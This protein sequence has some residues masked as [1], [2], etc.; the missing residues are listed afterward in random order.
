MAARSTFKI[1]DDVRD[2]LSRSTITA[3]TVTLPPKQLERKLYE[4]VNKALSGAGG[5]WNKKAGAH[6]FVRDPREVLGLAVE[7]GEAVNLKTKLQA[8]YTPKPLAKR[9]VKAATLKHGYRV[10][11]PS[12]GGGALVLAAAY[13][14]AVRI[15][16]VDIDPG[17]M[18]EIESLHA[19]VANRQLARNG[20]QPEWSGQP[21]SVMPLR[22]GGSGRISRRPRRGGAPDVSL[23]PRS[24]SRPPR[25]RSL[26]RSTASGCRE[27]VNLS[28]GYATLTRA[29]EPRWKL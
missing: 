13:V 21:L 10:L 16:A 19:E 22:G 11:E 20:R 24:A 18:T 9:M 15:D 5:K 3:T 23:P 27:R 7:T 25:R 6:V 4:A 29:S 28:S 12:M 8:F 14:A 2:V 1:S 26:T 17:V